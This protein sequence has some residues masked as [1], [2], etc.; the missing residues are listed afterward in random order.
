[1][2]PR[3]RTLVRSMTFVAATVVAAG[4]LAA[5]SESAEQ[6]P[7]I[8]YAIDNSISTYN[9]NTTAGSVSGAMAAF[10]RVLPG[11]TF[12]GPAGAPVS[13]RSEERRVGQEGVGT[14]RSR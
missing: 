9:A 13:A 6:V 1:M 8:G 7:S 11:F 12:T 10:G 5:C 3:T 14:C 4:S 2:L